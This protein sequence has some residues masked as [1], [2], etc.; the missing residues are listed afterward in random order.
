MSPELVSIV[1]LAAMFV[2]ATVFPVN[3][4]ILAFVAA[5]VLGSLYTGLSGE[6][7]TLLFPGDLFVLL[8]GVTFLFAIAQSNGTIDWLVGAAVRA[9]RG[10]LVVIPWIMF[11]VAG[12]LT[13]V[14]AVSPAAVAILAPVALG[15]GARYGVGQLLMGLMVVHGA[16]AGGFSPISVYGVIVRGVVTRANLPF[17]DVGLFLASLVVNTVV[18]G[19]AFVLFGGL[20]LVRRGRGSAEPS[21]ED[22]AHAPD[23]RADPGD[24]GDTGRL[25]VQQGLTVLGLAVLAVAT[26]V[27]D[28]DVGLTAFTVALALAFVSPQAQKQAISGISWSVVLLVGGVLTYVGVLEEIGTI[29]YVG[30]AVA[31]LGTPLLVGLLL[32]Y[33]GGVVSA[34]ASS[35]AIL[36]ATIPWPCRSCKRGRSARW[37]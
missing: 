5:F 6:D 12:I 28:L 4:G 19:V 36:G 15:V 18:A 37:P 26:V 10:R 29:S 33:I 11:V 24:E 21:G 1:V 13:A 16:Q 17:S 31:D 20:S 35:T 9:V 34:F 3:I 23:E 7:I 30:N 27:F 32:C 25:T 22:R 8:A 2:V 14:G